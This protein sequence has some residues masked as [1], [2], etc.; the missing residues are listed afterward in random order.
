MQI[1]FLA[2]HKDDLYENFFI[3]MVRG[4][5]LNGLVSFNS[6]CNKYSENL[7]IVRPLINVEKKELFICCKKYL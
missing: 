5:G 3:R 6:L 2:H 1:L 4:S 7:S